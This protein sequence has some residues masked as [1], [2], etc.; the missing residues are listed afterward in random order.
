MPTKIRTAEHGR[1]GFMCPGC[2]EEHLVRLAPAA[3]RKGFISRILRRGKRAIPFGWHYNGD[4]EK[5]TI[6]PSIPV[7]DVH[8]LEDGPVEFICHSVVTDGRI[9]FSPSS[10]HALAGQTVDLPDY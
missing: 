1:I 7:H 2:G 5:P 4:A 3:P 10:S 9:I 8:T 6:S